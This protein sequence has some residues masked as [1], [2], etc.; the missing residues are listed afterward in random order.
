MNK[1][2]SKVQPEKL[3]LSTIKKEQIT[4]YRCDISPEE[5]YLQVSARKIKKGTKVKAHKH[6]EV[7]RVSDITQESW[8]VLNGS[9]KGTF[10]DL[11][12]SF[13]SELI[14]HEGDVVVLFRGGHSLEVLE[15]NT[16]FY[17]FKTGPYLGLENDKEDI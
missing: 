17:E 2:F 14:L 7:D 3:I 5:E 10:Y 8:I 6:I 4:E 13:L 1:I 12:G 9:I 15:E 11:D 16:I